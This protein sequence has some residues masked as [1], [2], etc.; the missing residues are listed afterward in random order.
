MVLVESPFELVAE[1]RTERLSRADPVE[2]PLRDPDPLRR[3]VDGEQVGVGR[4]G[5]REMAAPQDGRSRRMPEG[6]G[7]DVPGVP[8]LL[9]RRRRPRRPVRD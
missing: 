8:G 7:M 4:T 1:Q 3:E 9:G 2:E 5:V 6:G